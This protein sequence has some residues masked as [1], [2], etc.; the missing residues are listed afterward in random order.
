MANVIR[1]AQATRCLLTV[2]L[3]EALKRTIDDNG[4]GVGTG[5]SPG[6]AATGPI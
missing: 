5:A 1:H 3:D 4:I 2:P 6:I